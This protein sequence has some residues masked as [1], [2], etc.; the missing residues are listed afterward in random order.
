MRGRSSWALYKWAP[1]RAQAGVPGVVKMAAQVKMVG[2]LRVNGG[3]EVEVEFEGTMQE[4]SPRGALAVHRLR[5]PSPAERAEVNAGGKNAPASPS[6][7]EHCGEELGRLALIR[8]AGKGRGGKTLICSN[9]IGSYS[10]DGKIH[11][12]SFAPF[13]R[14]RRRRPREGEGGA[15]GGGRRNKP[16]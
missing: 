16:A 11:R 2:L 9:C 6:L 13:G 1:A 3:D 5:Q 12:I 4:A 15:H 8:W 10:A 14:A 7:C